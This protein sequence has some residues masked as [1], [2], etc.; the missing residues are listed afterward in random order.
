MLTFG[1]ILGIVIGYALRSIFWLAD[2]AQ[3]KRLAKEI[4]E[5][6]IALGYR[7]E[8]RAVTHN[9]MLLILHGKREDEHAARRSEAVDV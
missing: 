6:Q 8:L 2:N 3:S 5:R 4:T 1:L 7:V 9:L